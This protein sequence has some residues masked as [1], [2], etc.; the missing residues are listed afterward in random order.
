LTSCKKSDSKVV[1]YSSCEDF[2]NEHMAQRLKEQF[3]NYNIDL[4]YLSTGNNG[5]KL[6]AEGTKTECDIVVGLEIGYLKNVA[7]SLADLSAMDTAAY[8]QDLLP[9][10]HTYLPWERASGCIAVRADILKEKGIAMPTSYDDLLKPE[11]K[12]LISMPNPKSSG[13]GYTFLKSLV[14]ARGEE[15]AFAYFDKLAENILQFT[16]SGSGPINALVQ[17]EA[18]IGLGMTFQAVEENNKG[19]NI[20][21]LYFDEGAPCNLTGSGIIKGKE[22]N[23]AVK[24]V[25]DFIATTL[26]YEDKELYSPEQI[27]NDQK[28]SVKN[29]PQAIP[30]ADMKTKG[31][32]VAEKEALLAKWTH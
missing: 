23:P 19:A 2:R 31:D 16:S 17:G 14:N 12:G 9:S 27:F 18:A 29:Y 24:E 10:D 11:Y 3:P 21:I 30:Y 5:A 15:K 20:E 4:Q 26:V 28:I 25:F 7:G 8:M 1:I 13:T 32:M 22:S 6:K